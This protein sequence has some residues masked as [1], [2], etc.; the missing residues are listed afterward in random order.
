MR[1]ILSLTAGLMLTACNAQATSHVPERVVHQLASGDACGAG[2]RSDWIGRDRVDLPTPPPG[3]NWRIY[4]SG[5]ALT[6]D[7]R[8]ERL[9]IEIDPATQKVARL[10]CG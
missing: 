3:A 5:D 4:A 1:L 2:R 8:V 9:N 6:E 10:W 7:L